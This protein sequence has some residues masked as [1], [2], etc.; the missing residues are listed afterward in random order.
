MR[1]RWWRADTVANA[2]AISSTRIVRVVTRSGTISFVL[3]PT[4]M[5][6][7]L[8][9][10]HLSSRAGWCPNSKRILRVGKADTAAFDEATQSVAVLGIQSTSSRINIFKLKSFAQYMILKTRIK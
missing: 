10:L 1:G 7:R 2:G 3:E 4:I 6:R 5:R 9:V 8:L